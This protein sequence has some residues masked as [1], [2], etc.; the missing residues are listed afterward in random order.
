MLDGKS[1]PKHTQ[2]F[3]EEASLEIIG[4]KQEYLKAGPALAHGDPTVW[5]QLSAL[6][7]LKE[8]HT[9]ALVPTQQT[10]LFAINFWLWED[11]HGV[12]F[13][14]VQST[15]LWLASPLRGLAVM[16][17]R[18][19][20]CC[21]LH[22]PQDVWNPRGPM[23]PIAHHDDW[24]HYQMLKSQTWDLQLLDCFFF[25]CFVQCFGQNS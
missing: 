2:W 4:L 20:A 19:A 7:P 18:S 6:Q 9:L 8:K 12:S 25:F 16:H 5:A 11:W 15:L 21:Q 14:L 24:P 13:G 1:I 3:P 22:L 23:S 10:L 17:W